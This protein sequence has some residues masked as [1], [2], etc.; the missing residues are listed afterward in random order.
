MP[1]PPRPTGNEQEFESLEGWLMLS[2]GDPGE[3]G[4]IEP[5]QILGGPLAIAVFSSLETLERFRM[6]FPNAPPAR[7][8][9]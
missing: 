1:R 3:P 4:K 9:S 7:G 6:Q 2:H 5:L 8:A